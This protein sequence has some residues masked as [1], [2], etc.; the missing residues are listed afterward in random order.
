MYKILGADQREY[1]PVTADQLR[2]WITEGRANSQTMVQ[3]PDS[4]E[5]KPLSSFLEFAG[6]MPAAGAAA[7]GVAAP[8]SYAGVGGVQPVVPN[9]LWQSI[10]VTACCCLP[11]GIAAIVFAAQVNSKLAA[12]DVQGAVE[13]SRKAKMW[14]WIAFGL[15]I[16]SNLVL[17]AL[18]VAGEAFQHR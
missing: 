5:W 15:G 1:G 4:T 17:V 6:V 9:Y 2:Q 7:P 16:I 3:G 13:S 18:S 14:C 10:V 8:T 11:F 12:G